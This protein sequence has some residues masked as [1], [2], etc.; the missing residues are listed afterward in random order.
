VPLIDGTVVTTISGSSFAVPDAQQFLCWL[1]PQFGQEVQ[2]M[3]AVLVD[4]NA[5]EINH[6]AYCFTHIRENPFACSGK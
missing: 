2:Q 4:H 1:F 6:P 5:V 3:D